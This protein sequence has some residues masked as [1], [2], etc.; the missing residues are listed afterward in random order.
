M[1]D[2]LFEMT[3]KRLGMTTVVDG[4]REAAGHDLRRRPA[5]A[6]GAPRLHAARPHRRAVHDHGRG[7]HRPASSSPP[8]AWPSWRSAGSPSLPVVDDDGR[9]E[10]VLHLHDLWKT[11]M[12]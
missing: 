5:P 1:K 9:V 11:E 4:G 12:I 7:G 2:V 8:R 10:G 3:R 6:D